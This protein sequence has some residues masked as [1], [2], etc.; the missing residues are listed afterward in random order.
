MRQQV[1]MAN[2]VGMMG[3][4]WKNM[5]QS[6][7]T[8]MKQLTGKPV[9]QIAAGLPFKPQA[10]QW[11]APVLRP[12]QQ[13][14]PTQPLATQYQQAQYNIPGGQSVY[15]PQQQQQIA[16]D[17]GNYQFGKM[18]QF[19]EALP[20]ALGYAAAGAAQTNPW[21]APIGSALGAYMRR[22]DSQ[23]VAPLG[24]PTG[25]AI[26]QTAFN[27]LQ[28]EPAFRWMPR[29]L[30]NVL[31]PPLNPLRPAATPVES[32]LTGARGIIKP[33]VPGVKPTPF[34][35]PI[36]ARV[37][38][39]GTWGPLLHASSGAIPFAAINAAF[40]IGSTGGR[41]SAALD[42]ILGE[43]EQAKQLGNSLDAVLPGLSVPYHAANNLFTKTPLALLNH[44]YSLPAAVGNALYANPKTPLNQ[45]QTLFGR[46][47]ASADELS[48]LANNPESLG[49]LNASDRINLNTIYRRNGEN[50]KY[51]LN[52]EGA[53]R[54]VE[55]L[56]PGRVA[57]L[58]RTADRL[59]ESNPGAWRIAW[60]EQDDGGRLGRIVP[61]EQY[62]PNELHPTYTPDVL[63]ETKPGI[64]GVHS[65]ADK[66][67]DRAKFL[68]NMTEARLNARSKADYERYA[69]NNSGQPLPAKLLRESLTNEDNI[70]TWLGEGNG[71]DQIHLG[72]YRW[73][74]PQTG[75]RYNNDD[76][77][78]KAYQ[79]Q[80]LDYDV[81][82]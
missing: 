12:G 49:A 38:S 8:V 21:T 27:A 59:N 76:P 31:R 51:T 62:Q 26:Q 34:R 61:A 19:G 80:V 75:T 44:P 5:G 15:P 50:P 65:V 82:H 11:H 29:T 73:Y 18:Q 45:M 3:N 9:G 16:N 71:T 63:K 41:P 14:S 36:A 10:P 22:Q 1:K 53:M 79:Q 64:F 28:T 46:S 7:Q 37:G 81:N 43:E 2:I 57:K 33:A 39:A 70:R 35:M 67:N 48:R 17:A 47:S 25:Q 4:A 42:Q 54:S 56:D 58:K 60:H 30:K 68:A 23:Q 69:H 72:G 6:A 52:D 20:R 13:Q 55:Q 32:A 78:V 66:A 74:D 24:H 40:D 77:V